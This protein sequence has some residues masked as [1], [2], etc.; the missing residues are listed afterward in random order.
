MFALLKQKWCRHR[1]YLED[2]EVTGKQNDRVVFV[3]CYR[4]GKVMHARHGAGALSLP[5][6][7]DRK[8]GAS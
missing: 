7:Y 3:R 8:G 2:I 6:Q 1:A 4:C 5:V